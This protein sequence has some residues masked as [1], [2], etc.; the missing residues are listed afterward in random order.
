[1]AAGVGLAGLVVAAVVAVAGL[2]STA[3]L[4]QLSAEAEGEASRRQAEVVH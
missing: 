3:E 4:V 1:M 2:V